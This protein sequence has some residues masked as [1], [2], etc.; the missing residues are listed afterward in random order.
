MQPDKLRF[1]AVE[2]FFWMKEAAQ[3]GGIA[4]L[5]SFQNSARVLADL[6]QHCQLVPLGAWG[7]TR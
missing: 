6:M 4:V 5:R 3:K 1:D 2:E 7:E